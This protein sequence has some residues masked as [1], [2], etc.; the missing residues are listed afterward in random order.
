MTGFVETGTYLDRILVRTAADL[1]TRK[2]SVS[3]SELERMVSEQNH[4]PLSLRSALIGQHVSVISEIKRASPSRGRFPVEIEPAA[5]AREYISGGAAAIS[6]LTDEPFFQGSL[7]DMADAAGVAHAVERRI[8]VLRKDFVID[9]YQL[10]EARAFGAD[11]ALLIVAALG[12]E[13]LESLSAEARRLGLSALVEVHNEAEL[14]RAVAADAEII[15]INNRDL[16]SFHVD[17]AVSERLAAGCPD[18]AVIVAESGMFTRGD[19]ERLAAAGA[20]AILV[21]EALITAPD[22]QLALQDLGTVRRV[23]DVAA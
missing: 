18:S 22:R 13:Q 3:V 21:G 23:R 1:E 4:Q 17:L 19:V 12:Q 16:H 5:V 11:A 8:P 9:P 10:L 6:V 2:A 7:Q 15:G 20:T 14:D